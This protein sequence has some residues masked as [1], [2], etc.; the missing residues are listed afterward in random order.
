MKLGDIRATTQKIEQGAWVGDLPNL[1]GISVKV[2]GT[3]NADYNRMLAK[4]RTEMSPD[5]WRN[6]EVQEALDA[7]LLLD[8]I[9]ID[10]DGIEDAEY[11]RQAAQEMLTNPEYSVFKRA[12]AYAGNVVAREGKATLDGAIKNSPTPSDGG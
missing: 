12:V 9:L 7:Q 1:P 2:R 8:T 3:F 4:L 5:E 10:W 11:S 6:T